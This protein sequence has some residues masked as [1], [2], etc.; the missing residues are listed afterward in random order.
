MPRRVIT[1]G[2][3]TPAPIAAAIVAA[4]AA[5]LLTS[6][7]GG[8]H[9]IS[10][11]PERYRYA[12][13]RATP[14]VVPAPLRVFAV[15]Y[16]AD[17]VDEEVKLSASAG[18]TSYMMVAR[19][20]ESRHY[21]LYSKNFLR[22]AGLIG[23]ADVSGD[24]VPEIVRWEQPAKDTM[25]VS[26]HH[27]EIDGAFGRDSTMVSIEWEPTEGLLPND[28]WG[29]GLSLLGTFDRD[30]D[31]V[32]DVLLIGVS[33]GVTKRPR[34]VWFWDLRQNRFSPR[35]E[36][37]GTP[38]GGYETGDIDGDG[39]DELVVGV[40]AP[41]NGVTFG[42][43]D[44]AHSYVVALESDG[45][46]LWWR[47]QAGYSSDAHIVL[48]DF[49]GDG[50]TEVA[51][52]VGGHNEDD[53]DRY[54]V[55]ILRGVDGEVLAADP[56][57]SSV[58]DMTC[59]DTAEG[60]RLFT[61]SSD[62]LVRRY[63]WD[64][65]AL[66]RD[67]SFDLGDSVEGLRAMPLGKPPAPERIAVGTVKGLVA[68]MDG[69]LRPLALTDL[70]AGVDE[71]RSGPLMSTAVSV[72]GRPEYGF[73]V[74]GKTGL[75]RLRLV[76]RPLP[77]WMTITLPIMGLVAALL[78][79]PMT[80][81]AGVA[82]LRRWVTPRASR[83]EALDTLLGSLSAAS[84]G[85]LAATSTLRRLREQFRMLQNYEGDPPSAFT[86]RFW[87]AASDVLHVGAP[88]ITNI[89]RG[90]EKL[91]LAPSRTASLKH[92]VKSLHRLL[93]ELPEGLP[94][95]R[96]AEV[97]GNKLDGIMPGIESSLLAVRTAAATE[98][99]CDPVAELQRALSARSA[100]LAEA[101][102]RVTVDGMNELGGLRVCG[103][104]AEISFVLENLIGNA[105]EA[106]TA[107]ET[108]ELRIT[109][110]LD[111]DRLLVRVADSGGGVR[112]EDRRR[113]FEAG[114][115]ARASGTGQG[116]SM[117]REILARRW[118]ALVLLESG[119]DEGAVFRLTLR[120]CGGGRAT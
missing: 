66:I 110:R 96:G 14:D 118:G 4:S 72:D 39:D 71:F 79:V 78:I 6:C 53:L 17:G 68:V 15:D 1:L 92:G 93:D 35:F 100:E 9:R 32:A 10:S 62:G 115:S 52:A 64:G 49:D 5:L 31:G 75:Y 94:S 22:P 82:T 114:W 55:Y 42:E 58:N 106:L 43:W 41:S 2:G 105:L 34:G 81:R 61:G 116:L 59:M 51:V 20:G 107:C 45:T 37:A 91:G 76:K 65:D 27:F 88:A 16:D 50:A 54:G 46:L 104:P 103:T 74:K 69:E 36:L 29:T 99:S 101:R 21:A 26:A 102:V 83:G 73:M 57:G 80:R 23:V 19:P 25:V 33:A 113:I 3:V 87:Q 18:G 56:L 119:P 86:E 85:R 47:E 67:G 98:R 109:A 8:P 90:A 13:V 95:R 111:G 120:A 89:G 28:D 12:L 24:G 112:D 40:G 48:G 84:H 44:D 97:L 77:Y 70:G 108:R 117:S 60:L 30:E 63:R 7:V 38:S 11:H